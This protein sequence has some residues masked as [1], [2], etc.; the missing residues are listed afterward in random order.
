MIS[1]FDLTWSWREA[2]ECY[3][4]TVEAMTLLGAAVWDPRSRSYAS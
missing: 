3:G 1:G 4:F 2:D